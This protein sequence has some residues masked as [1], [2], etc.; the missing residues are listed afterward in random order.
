MNGLEPGATQGP[1]IDDKAVL[2]VEEHIED[3]TK[4]GA[5]VYLCLG[6]IS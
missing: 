4:K 2:K 5:K 1:L 3:A 6:G